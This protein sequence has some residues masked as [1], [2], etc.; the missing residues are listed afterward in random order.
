VDAQALLK[1]RLDKVAEIIK[2][3]LTTIDR[4]PEIVDQI[5]PHSELRS[6]SWNTLQNVPS[7]RS[8]AL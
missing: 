2:R 1:I 3:A 5:V 6:A 7:T 8:L 4:N